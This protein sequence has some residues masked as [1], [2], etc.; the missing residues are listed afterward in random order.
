MV[1]AVAIPV[2]AGKPLQSNNFTPASLA[3][4]GLSSAP[5]QTL[6]PSIGSRGTTQTRI[7]R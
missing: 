2:R 3:G 6:Y 1:R 4:S 7:I 5:G